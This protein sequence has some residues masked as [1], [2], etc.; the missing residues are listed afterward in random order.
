MR[1]VLGFVEKRATD[2]SNRA[3]MTNQQTANENQN[4]R[5][6]WQNPKW[7]VDN[8]FFLFSSSYAGWGVRT[9]IHTH[10]RCRTHSVAHV[11]DDRKR[12]RMTMCVCVCVCTGFVCDV[13]LVRHCCRLVC[14]SMCASSR[15][16][17]VKTYRREICN[18]II[19][20]VCCRSN[21]GMTWANVKFVLPAE[22]LDFVY[23]NCVEYDSS[24]RLAYFGILFSEIFFRLILYGQVWWWFIINYA[25][26]SRCCT[27]IFTTI[28]C[29]GYVVRV[30][31]MW[32]CE[33]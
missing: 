30:C 27:T 28:L 22:K 9:H 23:L 13:K 12:W 1:G 20:D 6:L 10:T 25:I 21:C 33:L 19:F 5:T 2:G 24:G 7:Y 11:I 8:F 17:V 29:G 15:L 18:E 26:L 14:K 32:S 3:T 16:W 31:F 4:C